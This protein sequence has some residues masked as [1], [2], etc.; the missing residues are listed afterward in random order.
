MDTAITILDQAKTGKLI[1]L[2]AKNAT[3]LN[4]QIH[5]AAVSTLSH[6]RDYG[7]FTLA[8]RLLNALPTGQR[9]KTLAA[10]YAH[11]S[12][13]AFT[14]TFDKGAGSWKG[15]LAK[16][17]T[18]DQ[19]DVEGAWKVPFGDL[20][21][22]KVAT[23]MNAKAVIAMLKRNADSTAKNDDGTPK[24]SD[25]AKALFAD[26]FVAASRMQAE[27]EAKAAAAAKAAA[28]AA[29]NLKVVPDAGA[30]NDADIDALLTGTNG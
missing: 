22:E 19:F 1:T 9:V 13:N 25:E 6:I 12:A 10:W 16:K 28:R 23:T 20:M 18:P 24:I 21:P 30:N 8:E 2:I 7:D 11:F 27:N 26:L 29:R 14:L 4:T 5:I 17:R 15:N 3:K